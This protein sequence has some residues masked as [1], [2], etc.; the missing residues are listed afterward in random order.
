MHVPLVAIGSALRHD[1]SALPVHA[2][3]PLRVQKSRFAKF[4]LHVS[5]PLEMA[6]THAATDGMSSPFV[7][8]GVS[9]GHGVAGGV[10]ASGGDPPPR[11]KE[12]AGFLATNSSQ[13]SPPASTVLTKQAP[14]NWLMSASLAHLCW[15]AA[16]AS[17]VVWNSS[18]SPATKHAGS[19][20]PLSLGAAS[21]VV[22]SDGA[23]V[24]VV[25]A[26]ARRACDRANDESC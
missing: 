2:E 11:H 17:G 21:V 13:L 25:A 20:D 15:P 19:A 7:S 12:H 24:A 16:G 3:Q 4:N 9:A 5:V 22:T 8:M 6:A 18:T 10:P 14:M 23:S 1:E 26:T